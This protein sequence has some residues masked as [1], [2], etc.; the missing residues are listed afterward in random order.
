MTGRLVTQKG[1][2][3]ILEARHLLS[4][5]AQFVFLGTGEQRY[6]QALVDLATAAPEQIA[7][8]LDFTDRLEHRLMAGAD[9]FLMPSL[10]EP[11]GLT[12][13]R[14]QR[15]GS[16]PIVRNV[17]GL[18]DTVEDGVTGFSFEAYTPEAFEEA[19]FRAIRLLRAT[20]PGGMP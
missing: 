1:L 2:D 9:I 3:L 8:Q 10:Y 12:Q 14:A 19:G 5:G 4:S 18:A 11:C 20:P 16:P 15:Y 17:G 7:V 13:M 6:E